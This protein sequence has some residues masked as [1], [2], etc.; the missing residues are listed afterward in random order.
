MARIIATNP[1]LA[2]PTIQKI[3]KTFSASAEHIYPEFVGENIPTDLGTYI[4]EELDDFPE[5]SSLSEGMDI[6]TVDMT[7]R[8]KRE[9]VVGYVGQ[10]YEVTAQAAYTDFH[11]VL[12]KPTEMLIQS[13][14]DAKEQRGA[15][16]FNNGFTAPSSGGT[17][18]VDDKALFGATH[19]V[20][21]GQ[22]YSN[23]SA[24]ALGQAN[25][26][27]AWQS[28]KYS[29]T[30]AGKVWRGTKKFKLWHPSQLEDL[31]IRLTSS[32]NLPQSADNDV[33]VAKRL[34]TPVC[35]PHLTD[36]NNWGIIPAEDRFNPIFMMTRMPRR[37]VS[38][39]IPK[40]PGDMFYGYAEEYGFGAKNWR[41]TFGC[42]PS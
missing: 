41:G 38:D 8:N 40:R 42:N 19:V 34:V 39:R 16:V 31:A 2:R 32:T 27:T 3:V 5:A 4:F 35:I 26:A 17:W 9:F 12:K 20:G 11:D 24:L 23:A 7:S 25:L 1:E 28:A 36:T 21:A 10:G 14:D 13:L 15:N 22:T 30:G 37:F 6:P 33:N 29:K 18:T